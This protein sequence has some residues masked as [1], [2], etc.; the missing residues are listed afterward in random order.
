MEE[1]MFGVYPTFDE[2]IEGIRVL[3]EEIHSL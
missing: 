2:F 3:E 1:M